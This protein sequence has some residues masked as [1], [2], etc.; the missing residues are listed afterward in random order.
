MKHGC[1][2]NQAKNEGAQENP[3]EANVRTSADPFRESLSV[4]SI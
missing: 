3:M 1:Q 2:G 4:V